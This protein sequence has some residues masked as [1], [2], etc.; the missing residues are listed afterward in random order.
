[1]I[2]L[3]E[4]YTPDYINLIHRMNNREWNIANICNNVEETVDKIIFYIKNKFAIDDELKKFFDYIGIK[5]DGSNIQ[6][7]IDYLI[8]LK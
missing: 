7:F 6:K 5:H 2:I 1:M 4:L 3:Y 8:A